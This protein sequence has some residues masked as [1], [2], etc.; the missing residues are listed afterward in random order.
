M[1]DSRSCREKS[2]IEIEQE[3]VDRELSRIGDLGA[4]E[5]TLQRERI[6]LQREQIKRLMQSTPVEVTAADVRQAS[7]PVAPT[8]TARRSKGPSATTLAAVRA[9]GAYLY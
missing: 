2:Y 1:W 3:R 5:R 7:A 4:I 8:A 6:R 9:F